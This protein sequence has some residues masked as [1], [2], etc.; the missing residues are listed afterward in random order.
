MIQVK[1]LLEIKIV[2]YLKER[3]FEVDSVSD[4]SEKGQDILILTSP[5]RV[6]EVK[7]FPSRIVSKGKTK[8]KVKKES[9]RRLQAHGWIWEGIAQLVDHKCNYR[10]QEIALG[11]P[12]KEYYRRYLNQIKWFREK[13]SLY[14]YLVNKN[15]VRLYYPNELIGMK[16]VKSRE[17]Q[18]FKQAFKRPIFK[19]SKRSILRNTTTN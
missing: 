17:A 9:Q 4:K 3:N 14:I 11:L 1:I 7:G 12:D 15:E 10:D 5:R 19:A 13:L 18:N 16:G 2:S 6:I 8:G